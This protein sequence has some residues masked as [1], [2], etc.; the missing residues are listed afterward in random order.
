M[1]DK[2]EILARLQDGDTVDAIA[3]EMTEAL[4]AAHKDFVDEAKRQE[5]MRAKE[6]LKKKEEARKYEAKRQA[7]LMMVDALIDYVI[8]DGGDAELIRELRET[9]VDSMMD[10][11]DELI[12]VCKSLANVRTLE[13][14]VPDKAVNWNLFSKLF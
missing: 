9:N 2:A 7:I 3:A 6:E 8:A 12:E 5:E 13:F 10:A 14:K 1:F 11:I 4:N